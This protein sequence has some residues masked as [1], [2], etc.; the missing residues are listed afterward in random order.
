MAVAVKDSLSVKL[1]LSD[2]GRIVI[3]AEM[4]QKLGIRGGDT[5]FATVEGDA[6]KI[7][8]YRARVQRVQES[9]RR[10]ISPDRSLAD[11]LIAER[12][13]EAR[14]EMEEALG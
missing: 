9:L 2:N 6:L 10:Y 3:P 5:V 7:E 8:S 14:R 4:R 12:R 11:E 13:E 1:R